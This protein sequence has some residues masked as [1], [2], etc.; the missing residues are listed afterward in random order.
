M[1]VQSDSF[2]SVILTEEDA[3]QFKQEL[4]DAKPNTAATESAI[5]GRELLTQMRE[6]ASSNRDG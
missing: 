3:D 6:A 1:A 5:R 4:R 2:S